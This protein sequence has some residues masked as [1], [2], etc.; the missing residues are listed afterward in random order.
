MRIPAR[1]VFVMSGNGRHIFIARGA[2]EADIWMA[3]IK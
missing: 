3:Q 2:D 1:V